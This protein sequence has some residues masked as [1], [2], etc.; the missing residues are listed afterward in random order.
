M[1]MS[2]LIVQESG[3]AEVT[4]E[5][6]FRTS[7]F[8]SAK[9]NPDGK[10]I[11]YVGADDKGV[12]NLF[13]ALS[14]A[15]ERQQMTFF[16]S[17]NIIQFYWS[18][19]GDKVLLL[20][21]ENGTGRLHLHGIDIHSKAHVVYTEK[22]A[23]VSAKVLQVSSQSNCA[24]IGL[25]HR[26]GHFHDVYV[27]DLDS[28]EFKLL[29]ENERF[30][31]FLVSDE[32]KIIL[33][34][35]INPDGSWT[36]FTERDDFF[37]QLEAEDA[38]QT[39]FLAYDKEDDVVYFLDTR[40]SNMSRLVAKSL[41]EIGE[42]VLGASEESDVDDVLFVDGKPKAYASYD[43]YKKWH[44]IDD[45]VASDLAFLEKQLGQ[46]FTVVDQ[47]KSGNLWIVST[48]LPDAGTHFWMYDRKQ[49]TLR[50]LYAPAVSKEQLCKMYPLIVDARDGKRLVC[51]YTLPREYDRG[52]SVDTPIPLVV[53]PHG[54]PFK[55]RDRFEF[56][57]LHQWLASCG[58]AV[59]SVNFR[60]SSGFGKEFVNDGNGQWGGKAHLD[61]IDAVEA[62]IAKGLTQRGKL[63][64]LGASYGG[65]ESL[66]SLTLTP[67]YF[68]CCVSICGPSRLKTVLDHV[69]QFWEF[70]VKPLSDKTV[71]F[72]KAAFITSM[73]GD[74]GTEEG[75]RYL[76][77][78][79]PLN[80]LEEIRVPL[81]LVHGK[82]DHIVVE[83]ESRQIYERMKKKHLDVTYVFLPDE[84][85]KIAKF[86]NW[87]VFLDRSERLLA[88][89]LGGKYRAVDQEILHQSQAEILN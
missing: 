34:M 83:R 77:R 29:L 63:G 59:L 28:G 79:S 39:E 12:P 69:P 53:V 42:Q 70:P 48:C 15:A 3:F 52:G 8:I 43:V 32:L 5:D 18:A 36:I 9:I 26:N 44:G 76:E 78:C 14:D 56:S 7:S 71:F 40:F 11:A 88:Q 80:Y 27:L 1:V 54:G 55:G 38:F 2:L 41:S 20:K 62:C 86:A 84:G 67:D 64:I 45:S 61:V 66:A 68:T 60:L 82:N 75:M 4:K 57:A 87:M 21:D 37:M 73:G 16:E 6:L 81:L 50:T 25:N 89:Y 17:P 19:K 24:A 85:H 33:K 72:T 58:Y 49:Q 65:Y 51:Y 30:A 31:K 47:S 23:N 22:F 74:P 46:D 10:S 35:Q 13:I